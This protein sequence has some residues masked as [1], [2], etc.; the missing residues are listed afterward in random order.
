MQND[1]KKN[2]LPEDNLLL[3][4][5]SKSATKEENKLYVKKLANAIL[6]VLYKHGSVKM[7]CVGA[8]SVNNADKA[9][10]IAKGEAQK[11]G[12]K[13]LLD[14]S[15]TTVEFGG[16]KKTGILKEVIKVD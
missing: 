1:E 2:V 15:F 5:G 12:E 9:F 7:R 14:E 16:E 11:S 13:L 4:S 8:G 10:I 6:Q 3:V